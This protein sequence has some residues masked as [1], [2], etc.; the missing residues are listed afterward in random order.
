MWLNGFCCGGLCG[1]EDGVLK[2]DRFQHEHELNGTGLDCAENSAPTTSRGSAQHNGS[3]HDGMGCTP[4]ILSSGSGSSSSQQHRKDSGGG[5]PVVER[6]CGAAVTG[7]GNESNGA[8]SG[9]LA[10]NNAALNRAQMFEFGGKDV[11]G[12]TSG[13]GAE[14]K[15]CIKKDS[16]VSISGLGHVSVVSNLLRRPTVGSGTSSSSGRYGHRQSSLALTPEE[17]PLDS[18]PRLISDLKFPNLLPPNPSIK[19]LIAFCKNDPVFEALVNACHRL[20]FEP[21]FVKSADAAL[22]AFQNVN[23]GGHHI[24]VVDARH[25]RIIEAD[26]LGRSIRNSKGSQHTTMVAVV[27]KSVFERDD[28]AV[29]SLLDVGYNRCIIESPHVSICS[30]ELRQIQHS[31]VRPQNVISTQQA[32]YTALQRSREAIIITDDSLRTQYANRASEKILNMKA[33]EIV[34]RSFSDFVSTDISSILSHTSRHKNYEGFISTRRKSQD[35]LHV[36]VRAIP[37][38]C[39]GR[40]PT[41]LVLILESPS[42]GATLSTL[43]SDAL[44]TL[45][46]SKEVAR[47]SLHSIRRGSFDVRSIAS[48]GL[49][50]TSLA[51]LTQLPLEAPITKV[52]SLLAQVQ[53]NCSQEESKLLDRVMEFLKREGLYS[54]QMKEIR[55][56]DPVATDLIGALL[57]QGPTNIMSSRRSSND[58]IIRGG[59]RPSTGSIVFT[60]SRETSQLSDLLNSALNWEFEIFKLEELT[61]KR[62]LVCLGLELFRRF[63]VYNTFNCDEMTFKL[64]LIEMEKHYHADNTY[65]NSTHAADVMQATAC[66]IQQLSSR[67]IKVMDRLDEATALIAAATHDIDHPGRSSA[68][69]CNSD[70]MLALLYNDICVLESHHAATT[71]RLTMDDDK[72][73]IFKHLDRE[74]YKLARSVIIDMI[75]ATEMTR[76]FEHLAKFVSVFGTE[77]DAKEATHD[78]D[79][80]QI[81]VRRMLIKCADVSNPTRPLK[82]CVEWARR[83]AEEYFTQTDEEK[84]RNLPIVM[85]MF[86]RTT[87]SISKSQIGF[88][89]YIIHDMMDTWN[90]FIEMPEIIRYM[91]QNYSKWKLFE[92]QGINTLTDIK[93]KQLTLNSEAA[94]TT[95]VEEL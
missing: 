43:T 88:I 23:S 32:L 82:F 30:S 64:W 22:E 58:S 53:E 44:Q 56:E 87:C 67:E 81:L 66:Y 72:I 18:Y 36:H 79:D 25:P 86:D 61:D 57:T 76:H 7:S 85:P 17:E 63:D 71:F 35:T 29:I 31:L 15:E 34:G 54:P 49:R 37:V 52:L 59:G 27:K 41:H 20:N 19:I 8:N 68:F 92:E 46:Q 3:S 1:T 48:D 10:N 95:S 74:T 13:T 94:G 84:R 91:E 55:T 45:P 50:R 2:G 70:N 5:G 51:K 12:G 83:I 38:S 14:E 65:H 40:N 6:T 78:N 62:P 60:K 73:N 21:T 89:E 4:S 16:I 26:V 39:I 24:I 28:T 33:D 69:L 42:G 90:S 9:K 75:L 47:G 11:S 93:R 77:V 80:N